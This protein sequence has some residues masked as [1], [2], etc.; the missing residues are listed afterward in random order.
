MTINE[1]DILTHLS[2][3]DQRI[4]RVLNIK[5]T[6][7]APIVLPSIKGV[8]AGLA[9][10]DTGAYYI[11]T[12]GC[13]MNRADSEQ[14]A[15]AL[16]TRGYTATDEP[17]Q[18]DV[19]VL[20][21]CSV[22]QSAEDRAASKLGMLR[23]L[24]DSNP[25]L[26]LAVAGCMVQADP[27]PL[28]RRFPWVD[29]FFPP[30]QIDKLVEVVPDRRQAAPVSEETLLDDAA[31]ATGTSLKQLGPIKYVPIIYGCNHRCAFCIV[32][33]RRGRERS[34][35]PEELVREVRQLVSQGVREVTLLGQNVDAYGRDLP[36]K[37]DLADLMVLL[38]DVEGLYRVR[39]LTSHP[40]DMPARLI[41]IMPTLDKACEHINL[42][43]QAGDNDI[44]RA[45]KRGY[46]T[47][48]YRALIDHI[49]SRMPN[50]SLATDIIVGFPGETEAQFQKTLDLI[51]E[52]RF[53]VVHV[54]AYSV[55]P[56]TTAAKLENDVPQKEKKARLHAV[57]AL[58]KRIAT[59]INA[60]LLGETVEIL[61]EGREE[62]AQERERVQTAG[63]VKLK[64]KRNRHNQRWQGRTRTNKLVFFGD[65]PG[66][67]EPADL[68]GQLVN[69]RITET[70]PWSLMGELT[71]A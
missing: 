68:T 16:E 47:D 27:A 8:E 58:Q 20:N 18:A 33:F 71:T 22:R 52:L 26:V 29:V 70:S 39:F 42:P 45:M 40:N 69:V 12:I 1:Q 57:E 3:L 21:T 35:P 44:L 62:E 24:K 25:N 51:E 6:E 23:P 60:K 15:A 11:W 66:I 28:R 49:R 19:I 36:G 10:P 32:P 41:D 5:E 46:T 61:V 59:E 53:D 67:K 13:Q 48:R 55:R 4:D 17:G 7:S 64:L 14:I 30:L 2:S 34:R 31:C 63:A 56:G 38:N 54:A 37:P 43:V 50:V 9:R 65:P